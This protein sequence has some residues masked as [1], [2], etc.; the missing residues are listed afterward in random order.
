MSSASP[1]ARTRFDDDDMPGMGGRGG[2]R[3]RNK[4]PVDTEK[5]YKLLEAR[6]A[7]VYLYTISSKS[8]CICTTLK[9]F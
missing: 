7:P 1:H 4:K 6:G 2:P 9:H 8:T 3:G 5:F